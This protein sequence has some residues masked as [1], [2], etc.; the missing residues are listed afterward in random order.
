V[1]EPN[2]P[3]ATKDFLDAL[4]QVRALYRERAYLVAFLASWYPSYIG[5]TDPAEPT[6]AVVTIQTPAG[7]MSWHIAPQDRELFEGIPAT[8]DPADAT[9]DGHTT[10]VKYV[11]LY[12]LTRMPDDDP[13]CE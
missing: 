6:Y 8:L 13:D 11:R 9:W 10:D 3:Q 2:I 5:Y 1:T 4:E 7:Q 12:N